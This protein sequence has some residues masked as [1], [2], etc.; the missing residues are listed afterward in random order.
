MRPVIRPLYTG[1][2]YAQ[3]KG[4]IN[5]LVKTFGQ[6]CSYC[7]RIDKV[8]VEHVIPKTCKMGKPLILNWDNF[9]LGCPRCNRDFKRA[10]NTTRTGYLWPDMD[11][12]FSCFDYKDDG[13][14]L[15]K[16]NLSKVTA[17]KAKKTLELMMLDDGNTN[18]PALNL[19]RRSH[20]VIA[21]SFRTNYLSGSQKI[22]EIVKA[23]VGAWSVWMTV[24]ID[25]PEVVNAL[26]SNC[27]AGTNDIYVY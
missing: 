14:L 11:D 24:F 3:Y 27:I 9:L 22:D 18:Q 25:Q 5:I 7:E 21:N 16:Q 10:K 1:T 17:Y 12:T 8:D 15:V 26:V 4:Y 19:H 13:R 20:F 2:K 23:S 6:N